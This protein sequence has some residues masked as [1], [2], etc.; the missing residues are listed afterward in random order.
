[1]VNAPAGISFMTMVDTTFVGAAG[2]LLQP[3]KD[4]EQIT[5]RAA[6]NELQKNVD[7]IIPPGDG[8]NLNNVKILYPAIETQVKNHGH[9]PWLW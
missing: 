2:F 8:D 5:I 9:R 3:Q 1:M 6:G 4:K 7:I